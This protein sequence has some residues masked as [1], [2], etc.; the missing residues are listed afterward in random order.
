MRV[1]SDHVSQI[2]PH[3]LTVNPA[4]PKFIGADRN[5]V[6]VCQDC[7]SEKSSAGGVWEVRAQS[8]WPVARHQLPQ[9]PLARQSNRF[10][11]QTASKGW[12]SGTEPV[13]LPLLQTTITGGGHSFPAPHTVF[14]SGNE[15]NTS[16]W[17]VDLNLNQAWQLLS[18]SRLFNEDQLG[19][20]R[21]RFEQEQPQPSGPGGLWDWLLQNGALTPYQ[22]KLF[23][24]GLNGPL[25]LD[26]YLL[27]D[28]VQQGPLTGTF[29]ARHVTS[30]HPVQLDFFADG[31]A[32]AQTLWQAWRDRAQKLAAAPHP[33]LVRTLEAVTL[34][35]HAFI[36]SEVPA[37]VPL[38]QK[39]PRKARLPWNQAA[40]I[41]AQLATALGVL[42]KIGLVHGGLSPR[43]VWL[44]GKSQVQLRIL[45][46]PDSEFENVQAETEEAACDYQA[47][48]VLG[49]ASPNISSDL[50][51]LGCLLFRL[52]T[53][54][55]VTQG[56]TLPEKQQSQRQGGT[57]DLSKYEVPP[58]MQQLLDRL[59]ARLP[60]ERPST[61]AEVAR[62]LADL[63]GQSLEQLFPRTPPSTSLTSLLRSITEQTPVVSGTRLDESTTDVAVAALEEPPPTKT[64]PP[65]PSLTLQELRA[66]RQAKQRRIFLA[67]ASSLLLFAA[68][69]GLLAWSLTW[70]KTVPVVST[71]A[72]PASST[73][74]AA[75]PATASSGEILPSEPNAVVRQ[76][77]IPDDGNTL[78]QAP[79][80]G[81]AANLN[82]LPPG[83]RI[84]LTARPS[85]LLAEPEGPLL[86]ES[87]DSGLRSTVNRWA[88]SIAT[89]LAEISSV[90][91]GLYPT[92]NQEYQALARITLA[93]PISRTELG[94][95]WQVDLVSE[96]TTNQLISRGNESIFLLPYGG[97][98]EQ[99]ATPTGNSS[100]GLVDSFLYG[101]TE[102]VSSARDSARVDNLSGPFAALNQALDGQR[103][104]NLLFQPAGLF[105]DEGQWLMSGQWA[106]LNRYLRGM[107]DESARSGLF[108]VHLDQGV[109]LELVLCHSVDKRPVELRPQMAAQFRRAREDV[110]KIL[111]TMS[112]NPYWERVRLRFDNML[113][114]FYQQLRIGV[115]RNLV[116]ANAW[117]PPMAAHNLLAA[118]ELALGLGD[119]TN[120]S[121][122]EV[123]A[124]TAPQTLEELLALPRSLSVTTNPDLNLLLQGIATEVNE[125]FPELPFKF[126]IELAGTDLAKE[127]ITQNQRP[128]DFTAAQRPLSAILTEIMLR[129]NP[130]K[131]AQKAS[132]PNCK[133]VWLMT[134]DPTNPADRIVLVTTRAA[135]A[136]RGLTLPADFQ[137]AANK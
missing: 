104:F 103:H 68:V 36:V 26:N 24:S 65:M 58:G 98:V 72:T 1:K 64:A 81:R 135:A 78:W 100:T 51:S 32:K 94:D 66:I 73:G 41:G 50:Y 83:A 61:A 27:L 52:V 132:D 31:S 69:L 56:S 23:T 39:V 108:S 38:E 84:V 35:D 134:L 42:E 60:A 131:S 28:R 2:G 33:A 71:A 105:N 48:E 86:F 75:T 11:Q 40:A 54:R 127:G 130:D 92:E 137:P 19:K 80:S 109:Y 21:A 129:A 49:G 10:A 122:A 117:L 47:P 107:L 9:P 82:Y 115:E 120:L 44:F 59:L 4:K 116:V 8:R 106:P 133:L 96:T 3:E 46:Q 17:K 6:P 14:F 114:D 88:N 57:R 110:V 30:Q 15:S 79:T 119:A 45:W 63:S 74:A 93:R 22:A 29:L 95:R 16:G 70:N 37:G 112:A 123:P 53:G 126:R 87:L 125:Q 12:Q 111:A 20:L 25:R 124:Q 85:V 13:C 89:P 43:S 76:S 118:T 5:R 99:T 97:G 55:P 34:T 67:T 101:P 77:I 18:L 102:L 7:V 62:S 91:V 90:V 128:G 113:N 121:V 136:E